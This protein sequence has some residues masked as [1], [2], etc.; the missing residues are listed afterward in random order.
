MKTTDL[1]KTL[2]SSVA[3]SGAEDNIV[4]LLSD[5]LKDYGTVTVDSFNN[6]FC[7]FGTGIHILID[8]HID[9][10]GLLVK[11][12]SEDGFI[13]VDKCGGVNRRM[14]LGS[15]VTVFGDAE[16]RGVISTLP[17]HLQKSEDGK[18]APEFEDVS[19]DVGM[20]KLEAEKHIHPGDKITFNRNFA[21]LIGNQV[22]G[23]ALDNR[24]GVAAVLL[25]AE[26][27]RNMNAKVT[28]MFSA[29]EEVGLR[30]AKIGAYHND[31]DEAI[32]VDVSFAYTPFCK[33]T[34]CGDIGKG[35]MIGISPFLDRG[36]S[37]R[38]I[39]I[40]ERE[41]IPYQTEVMS[42]ATGTN[43]DVITV[44]KSGIKAALL[45]IPEKYMHSTVEV[46]DITDI[47]NVADLI[48]AYVKERVGDFN[49]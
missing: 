44:T 19:I 16:Y 27:L 37:D 40:A 1:L 15:E 8:A 45:S 38:L 22:A 28:F 32:V 33:H 23:S 2:T 48:V 26:R 6:I 43:A 35:P 36:M 21:E 12:I 14:L 20:C 29:Q 31:I 25:A 24:A 3:V 47:E 49:A 46:V 39:G 13:K 41:G 7:T 10:I 34:D 5:I 9:E 18:M 30:G 42:G 4:H 17:P 11:N